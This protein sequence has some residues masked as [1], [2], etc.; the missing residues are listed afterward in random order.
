M[1]MFKEMIDSKIV[2]MMMV[3]VG[4]MVREVVMGILEIEG[5]VEELSEVI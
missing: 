5:K 2:V 3:K 4:T 1:T